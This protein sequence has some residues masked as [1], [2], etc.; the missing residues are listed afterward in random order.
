MKKQILFATLALAAC[1]VAN[2][3]L[4]VS[5][6]AAGPQTVV[7]DPMPAMSYL[8]QDLV[9]PAVLPPGMADVRLLEAWI[10]LYNH[11]S[12]IE[13]WDGRTVTGRELALFLLDQRIPVVWDTKNV[14][15]GGSCSVKYH[16]RGTVVWTFEAGAARVEPIYIQTLFQTDMV[17]LTGTLAHEAFHRTRPF[18][19]VRD[20]QFEEFWA[21][22]VGG[23]V[24]PAAALIFG[25]YDPFDAMHLALWY[26]DN[27]IEGYGHLPEYPPGIDPPT[28]NRTTAYGQVFGIRSAA[29]ATGQSARP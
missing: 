24:S 10:R 15:K 13:L 23:K 19:D 17:G 11:Q 5:T 20:S 25:P 12:P 8:S 2:P 6:A 18:G 1:L 28:V 3:G 21:Y 26:R 14:C 27:R 7:P 4:L 22:Y 16:T 29:Y 9:V